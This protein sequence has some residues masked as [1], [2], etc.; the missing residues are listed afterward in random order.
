MKK[1]IKNLGA[2]KKLTMLYCEPC[3]RVHFVDMTDICDKCGE[4]MRLQ[5]FDPI[6]EVVDFEVPEGY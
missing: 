1:V 2:G 5:E 4:K 6:F 3:N